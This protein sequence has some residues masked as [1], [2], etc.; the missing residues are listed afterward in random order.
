MTW[1]SVLYTILFLTAVVYVSLRGGAPERLAILTWV[2]S[3]MLSV[4]A[5]LHSPAMFE[6]TEYTV[7]AI[8]VLTFALFLTMA[9]FANRSWPLLVCSMQAC[10]VLVH[11]AN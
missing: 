11:L 8:D 7:F 5:L 6:R 9:L 10:G 4:V 2:V 3:N 1:H